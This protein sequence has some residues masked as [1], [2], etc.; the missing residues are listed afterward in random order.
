MMPLLIFTKC[1]KF[2]NLILGISYNT[3]FTQT[4]SQGGHLAYFKY[5]RV[6]FGREMRFVL[7]DTELQK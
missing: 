2:L 7:K 4:L 6:A 3:W 1:T 5:L